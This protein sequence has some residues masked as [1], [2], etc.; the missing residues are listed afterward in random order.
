ML[1]ADISGVTDADGIG[2]VSYKWLQD[3]IVIIGETGSTF[4]VTIFN[5]GVGEPVQIRS[6]ISYTDN[7]GT[8]E[9][10]RSQPVGIVMA[11]NNAP[12][13]EVSLAGTAR[14]GAT[15][16]AD[17]SSIEDLDGLDGLDEAEFDYQWVKTV[18][19]TS[20]DI[21]GVTSS[22]Y[23]LTSTDVGSTVNVRV[24][25]NDGFGSMEVVNSTATSAVE[26]INDDPTGLPVLSGT[27][28]TGETLTV[29][30]SSIADADGLGAMAYQWLRDGEAISNATN[31]TYVLALEDVGKDIRV[32]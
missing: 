2:T 5:V 1:T 17:A 14:Q 15:L 30:I 9:T 13:G 10:L 4:N 11:A 18:N 28:E 7:Y 32:R 31:S 16:T 26:N 23:T 21:P 3:G 25:Y 27:A 24:S 12:T 8:Q 20:T 29:D 22:S 6:E 19:G